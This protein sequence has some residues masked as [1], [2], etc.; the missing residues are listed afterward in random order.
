[1]CDCFYGLKNKVFP[2]AKIF[3]WMKYY[4]DFLRINWTCSVHVDSTDIDIHQQIK[5]TSDLL[6]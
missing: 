6:C 4:K 5:K 3:L 1:M 2:Q